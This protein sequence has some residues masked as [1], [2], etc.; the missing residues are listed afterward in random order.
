MKNKYENLYG[1]DILKE[2]SCL[3]ANKKFLLKM[4]KLIHQYEI[5]DM[6]DSRKLNKAIKRNPFFV[7][8]LGSGVYSSVYL[9]NDGYAYKFN[10]MSEYDDK[11]IDYAKVAMDKIHNPFF[12]KVYE[13]AEFEKSYAAKIELLTH[14]PKSQR[15]KDDFNTLSARISEG[16][17]KKAIK[18]L[19]KY[20]SFRKRDLKEWGESV[21]GIK[22][23]YYDIHG[24][25]IM[26]RGKEWV[27]SDPIV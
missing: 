22:G 17:S 24:A 9:A 25:N 16:S 6:F 12:P 14:L 20:S 23:R 27:F 21:N 5:D 19:S 2:I 1:D 4:C 26:L 15:P 11:W 7:K 10:I 18:E 8:K 3:P 13:I